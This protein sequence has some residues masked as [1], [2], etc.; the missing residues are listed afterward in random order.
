MHSAHGVDQRKM[1]VLAGCVDAL[2]ETTKR[3]DVLIKV[4]FGHFS[5]PTMANGF[6]VAAAV[7]SL[8]FVSPNVATGHV[9]VRPGAE[10]N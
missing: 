8:R 3:N 9:Q 10:I 5:V 6:F 1:S 2:S 7:R 4:L